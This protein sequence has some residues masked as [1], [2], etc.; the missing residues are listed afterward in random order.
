MIVDAFMSMF[1]DLVG[2]VLGAIPGMSDPPAN[3]VSTLTSF[4]GYFGSWSNWFFGA[5]GATTIAGMLGTEFAAA[6]TAVVLVAARLMFL[7]VLLAI[8]LGLLK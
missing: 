5:D 3:V 7:K 6:G 4:A 2:A 8:I 1:F